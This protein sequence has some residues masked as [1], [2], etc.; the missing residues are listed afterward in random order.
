MTPDISDRAAVLVAAA[1]SH[2]R[3]ATVLSAPPAKRAACTHAC[4]LDGLDC[5]AGLW[6]LR[7]VAGGA[8]K[9]LSVGS[10]DWQNTTGV[11]ACERRR[12]S[13]DAE[14]RRRRH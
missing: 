8:L 14:K 12:V 4:I 3:Q 6:M 10:V 11:A 5:W 7:T 9:Y 1:G 2:K 13:A